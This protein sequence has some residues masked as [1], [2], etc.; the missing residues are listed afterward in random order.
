MPIAIIIS[1]WHMLAKLL[2]SVY[3]IYSET[4]DD[5]T[6]VT[7][8]AQILLNGNNV[9]MVIFLRTLHGCIYWHYA[10]A[11]P[12]ST[13]RPTTCQ[14]AYIHTRSRDKLSV[15][16]LDTNACMWCW[17]DRFFQMIPG[18]SPETAWVD[19][20]ADDTAVAAASGTDGVVPPPPPP[21]SADSTA[22][23]AGGGD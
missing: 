14:H 6:R 23:A 16:R 2:W 5:G 1:S 15:R 10:F 17:D 18:G 12:L 4:T 13:P 20:E 22:A 9:C 11:L 8:L 21:G 3:L 19:D 7:T